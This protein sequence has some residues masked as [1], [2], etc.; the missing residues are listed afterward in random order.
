MPLVKYKWIA[1]ALVGVLIIG[2][3]IGKIIKE[4]NYA[5]TEGKLVSTQ[6]YTNTYK[7][8][9]FTFEYSIDDHYYYLNYQC[10]KDLI[11]SYDKYIILY[12]IEN[13][14][15]SKIEF[16]H[17][18]YSYIIV[19]IMIIIT[20]SEIALNGYNL[21]KDGKFPIKRILYYAIRTILIIFPFAILIYILSMDFKWNIIFND[22]SIFKLIVLLIVIIG[23]YIFINIL[24]KKDDKKV[25]KT[26]E[27]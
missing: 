14:S 12:D 4:S 10:N 22:P 19:G 8:P 18:A 24:I 23:I 1:Y 17:S 16:D 26:L 11:N 15:I 5:K 21:T 20:F 9:T 6:Y 25:I 13:P 3:C 7:N 27:K 2:I